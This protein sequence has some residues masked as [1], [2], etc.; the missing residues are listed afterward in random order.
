L[1]NLEP[2]FELAR[3]VAGVWVPH[4]IHA[5]ATLGVADGLAGG[6]QSAAA[7]AARLGV[8][9]DGLH[10]LLR[11][12]AAIGVCR[13]LDGDRFELTAMGDCLRADSPRSIRSWAL[14]IGTDTMRQTWAG[15]IDAVRTGEAMT[16]RPAG[17]EPFRFLTSQRP[18]YAANFYAAMNELTE[19]A[20]ASV[21][22]AYDFSKFG[23]IVDVGGGH[24]ALL[25]AV[26][27]ATPTARGVLFD[28]PHR[29]EAATA[30]AGAQGIADRWT[31]EAGTFFESVP[32]GGDA[33]LL[34]SVIHDWNDEE[35]LEILSRCRAAMAPDARLLLIEMVIPDSVQPTPRDAVILGT[36]LGLLAMLSGRER[37]AQAYHTLLGQAGFRVSRRILTSSAFDVIEAYPS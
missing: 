3:L 29:R 5:A 19:L 27:R 17:F 32:P 25:A 15:L 31:F 20:A 8:H 16:D 14:L 9:A 30:F 26:L 33:Y 24:G 37:T 1:A 36:D 35:S 6:A 28:L 23:T 12:L 11:S 22:E 13:S 21:V 18:D 10:R 4:A 2:A 34:K 7:L